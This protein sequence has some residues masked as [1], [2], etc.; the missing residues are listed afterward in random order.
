MGTSDNWTCSPVAI[1]L[2]SADGI[3]SDDEVV[4]TTTS[5]DVNNHGDISGP[6]DATLWTPTNVI[7]IVLGL[8]GLVA[9][10]FSAI[11]FSQHKPLRQRIPN[12]FLLNQSILDLGAGFFLVLD[13]ILFYHHST[14]GFLFLCYCYLID[15]HLIYYS[16][17][18]ASIW[19]LAALS[20]ERY[21]EVVHPILHKLSLTRSGD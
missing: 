8:V 20:V 10:L 16:L 2:T 6:S 12:Y 4:P 7:S 11:V 9:N 13:I 17:F 15:S 5:N 1:V 3:D 18:M 14:F 19:N 21:F